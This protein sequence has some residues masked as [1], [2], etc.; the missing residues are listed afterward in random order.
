LR[1]QAAYHDAA[2]SVTPTLI[3]QPKFARGG[4]LVVV[5]V[6]P[7]GLTDLVGQPLD[8]GDTGTFGDDGTFVSSPTGKGISR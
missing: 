6:P 4:K 7:G 8:G 2:H 3:G 1:F 5:G